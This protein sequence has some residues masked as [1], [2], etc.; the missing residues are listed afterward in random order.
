MRVS[1]ATPEAEP[2][3]ICAGSGKQNMRPIDD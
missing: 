1:G 2:A 3:S